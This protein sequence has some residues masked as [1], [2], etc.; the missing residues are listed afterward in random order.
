MPCESA[1]GKWRDK[2]T[3]Q[4]V[5]G[6]SCAVQLLQQQRGLPG[7][8]G[9]QGKGIVFFSTQSGT[10]DFCLVI[11]SNQ[12]QVTVDR[13]EPGD[14][15]VF[16]GE[17]GAVIAFV[18]T[19]GQSHAVGSE[20][21]RPLYQVTIHLSTF[22]N[23]KVIDGGRVNT[24]TLESGCGQ[25]QVAEFHIGAVGDTGRVDA[26][27][28]CTIRIIRALVKAAYP[29]LERAIIEVGAIGQLAFETRCVFGKNQRPTC[30]DRKYRPPAGSRFWSGCGK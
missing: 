5:K 24:F 30:S 19:I 29:C 14:S 22:I 11:F 1:G 23:H 3:A 2:K 12:F 17:I 9:T 4:P 13:V 21:V 20:R 6:S 7:Q 16:I 27:D 26:V 8:N 28:V 15:G 10:T 25:G 18:L